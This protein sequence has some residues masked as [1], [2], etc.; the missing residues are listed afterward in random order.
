MRSL[1]PP[2]RSTHTLGSNPWVFVNPSCATALIILFVG[3]V[4]TIDVVMVSL[5]WNTSSCS[6]KLKLWII[7]KYFA[8]LL[9][10]L[11]C[12][13]FVPCNYDEAL[14]VTTN[15]PY[16]QHQMRQQ[17]IRRDVL[18][19]PVSQIRRA[20]RSPTPSDSE[21]ALSASTECDSVSS[22][23]SLPYPYDVML[24]EWLVAP[25]TMTTGIAES[26]ADAD[27]CSSTAFWCRTYVYCV[28]I[29][30]DR[31]ILELFWL[32][33]GGISV[34]SE[35]A[36]CREGNPI[37]YFYVVLQIVLGALLTAL[38]VGWMLSSSLCPLQVAR[39]LTCCYG[40]ECDILG[41]L[42][43]HLF[44]QLLALQ[45]QQQQQQQQP[46]Q[47]QQQNKREYGHY[48]TL[49]TV[50]PHFDH[51]D[52]DNDGNDDVELATAKADFRIPS[53]EKEEHGKEGAEEEME[54]SVEEDTDF[55]TAI[56]ICG[57]CGKQMRETEQTEHL[58]CGHSFHAQCVQT[59]HFTCPECTDSDS[60]THSHCHCHSTDSQHAMDR[61]MDRDREMKMEMASRRDRPH[62]L[63]AKLQL[64]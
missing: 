50:P 33:I 53:A 9:S 47:Q 22:S 27:S 35:D 55:V 63:E 58:V 10:Y 57:V 13:L 20:V 15:I 37:L 24:S 16:S 1:P 41:L 31:G 26:M 51:N 38:L 18:R 6:D 34:V 56:Q 28:G 5:H 39:L 23:V 48:H 7:G 45:Q 17:R 30:F 61:D 4:F 32:F 44:Q 21:R 62:P 12:C 11:S 54:D 60:D 8:P 29:L 19:N 43:R 40:M 25:S 64:L 52:N 2:L 42:P 36:V 46:L 49:C 14:D 3:F 59:A